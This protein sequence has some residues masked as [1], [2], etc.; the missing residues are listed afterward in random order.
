MS[1]MAPVIGV[2]L[3][4]VS[5]S[6]AQSTQPTGPDAVR[7]HWE[8]T[9]EMP[10][11]QSLGVIIEL[12]ASADTWNGTIDIPM[13]GANALPLEKIE[14]NLPAVSFAI[15]GVPGAPTFDGTLD[16]AGI[17]G[18]F[19]QGGFK[20]P[21]SLT[22]EK[23]VSASILR[24]Q[25]PKPPFPYRE[26]AVKVPAGGHELAGTLVVPPGDGPKPVVIFITGSGPQ[27]RD[28]ELFGHKPFKLIAD[29]LARSGIASLRCDDRGTGEST[30]TLDGATS[31][32]FAKDVEAQMAFLSQ[33][34]DV[35]PSA[36]GLL[37]HSEGGLIAPMVASRNDAV[38]FAV[39]I[40]P[41]GVPGRDILVRQMELI[42][43]SMGASEEEIAK[44]LDAQ[45]RVLDAIASGDDA[46]PQL[47]EGLGQLYDLTPEA[48]R[49]VMG[50]RD[51]FIEQQVES[52][53]S[54][55]MR[56][57]VTYDPRVA[58]RKTTQPVLAIWGEKDLQ[59][60]P[61]QNA[62]EVEAALRE[63]DNPDMTMRIFDGL[64]HLMQPAQ[65]GSVAEYAQIETTMD[66]AVL[67]EIV[68]WITQRFLK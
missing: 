33:Q 60:E 41:P 54:P 7:G 16:G 68:E 34:S 6:V 37:G 45:A 4:A 29:R 51:A 12:K 25:E 47:R 21:F 43:R 24:P 31:E 17:S 57:F 14:I 19:S 40:A 59:V 28:E 48:L 2:L 23:S 3:A 5:L 62:G 65:T 30:G 13:Q 50:E 10:G 39:L 11:G 61:E 66:E 64:N 46:E 8:G 49:S 9:I 52:V 35:Q 1:K 56:A 15:K 53:R 20:L 63:A 44:L 18:T 55:W 36:I 58:L 27:N 42:S 32:D 38:K 26:V 22:R 67:D